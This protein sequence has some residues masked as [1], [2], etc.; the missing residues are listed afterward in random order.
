MNHRRVLTLALG[1]AT[2]TALGAPLL[3]HPVATAAPGDCGGALRPSSAI[4]IQECDDLERRLAKAAKVVAEPRHVRWQS[5]EITG[6]THFSMNTFTDREWGSG[7]E[8]EQVFAPTQVDTDQWMT[9]FQDMNAG[10][11]ML[12]AKHHDGFSLYPTRYSPHSVIASPWWVDYDNCADAEQVR[13]A[14]AEAEQNRNKGLGD[15]YWQVRDAG[16]TNPEGDILRSYVDSARAADLRVGVY[17]SPSD[18][19]ELPHQWH[20]DTYIPYVESKPADQRNHAEESTLE[21]APAPPAGLGRFGNSSEPTVRTIPTLVPGDDRADKVASGELPTFQVR[22]NDYDAYYLNQIYEILTEYGPID[23]FWLDGANPWAN[24]GITQNYDFTSW[25][26]LIEALSP[27]TLVFAGPQ[28]T[29]W[30]GNEAGIAR[31]TEWSAMPVTGDPDST[32]NERLI[33][34][35]AWAEDIGSREVLADRRIRYVQW[36]P[37]EADTSV[38]PGWFYHPDEAPKRA[39]TLVNLYQQ[40]VG[41]NAVLLLNVPPAPDGRVDDRDVASLRSFGESVRATYRTN[42]AKPQDGGRSTGLIGAL[43]DGDLTTGWKAADDTT[44]GGFTLRLPGARTF[45]QVRLGE[46]ITRGQHVERFTV[47]VW[48]EQSQSWR[49]IS[50]TEGSN[51]STTIGYSRILVLDAPATTDRIR[52]QVEQARTSPHITSLGLYL[53]QLPDYG[54]PTIPGDLAEGKKATQSSTAWGGTP[55]RAVDGNTSGRWGDGSIT[56]TEENVSQPWWQVDLGETTEIGSVELFNR[57]DCCSERLTD[58]VILL[59]DAPLPHDLDEAL[60]T[61]GVVSVRVDG[62]VGESVRVPISGHK[63]YVRVQLPDTGTLALAEVVVR[64]N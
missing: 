17:L 45:D 18:G 5:H 55:D 25:F 12:T 33:L 43:T 38:R 49:R 61:P 22:A 27:E 14:R 41:R 30:V 57:T 34:P 2:L 42:L 8:S 44:T 15:A 36:Y 62:T 56:H 29:R 54:P 10:L 21:D 13:A 6:F 51:T 39:Q 4:P 50:S 37:A 48:E 7:M 23:E 31:T 24:S 59:S 16:C 3:A 52:V 60:A 32:H 53:T 35:N 11:A 26:R 64:N 1:A 40:S 28:G 47:D 63:R 20:R 9:S 58:P 19:A 46:D